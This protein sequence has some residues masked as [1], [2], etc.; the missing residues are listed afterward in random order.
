MAWAERQEKCTGSITWRSGDLQTTHQIPDRVVAERIPWL[1]KWGK[2][3][4]GT[5]CRSSVRHFVVWWIRDSASLTSSSGQTMMILWYPCTSNSEEIIY[6]GK[7]GS[8]RNSM[9]NNKGTGLGVADKL[10]TGKKRR[11]IGV[12]FLKVAGR[13]GDSLLVVV[14][15][16]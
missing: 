3:E 9:T 7:I 14:T 6:S 11:L 16:A 5:G 15:R 13:G 4:N 1:R 12:P 2:L 10:Y 8:S